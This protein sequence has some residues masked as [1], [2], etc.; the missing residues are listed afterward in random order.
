QNQVRKDRTVLRAERPVSRVV[1][2]GS[3]DVCRKHVG[4]ELHT[5]KLQI[6]GGCESF[7]RERL[8][9]T[10]HTFE[11]DVAIAEE[12]NNQAIDELLLTT[13]RASHL[14][15]KR[16]HPLRFRPQSFVDGLNPGVGLTNRRL[17]PLLICGGAS[18]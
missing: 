9:E 3:D 13:T 4:R 11:K 16:L 1:D 2:H 7:E 12:T 6:D 5:L 14:L 10:G 17:R 18:W 8:R 15:T